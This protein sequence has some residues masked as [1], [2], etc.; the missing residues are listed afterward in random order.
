MA[1]NTSSEVAL[2]NLHDR[3]DA[4]DDQAPRS[5]GT[6][7]DEDHGF[8]F[9]L[10]QVDGGKEAWLLLA[11]SF[12]VEALTWGFPFSFG[13]FQEY[14]AT[15]EPFSREPSGI[16]II[17]SSAMGFMYLGLPFTFAIMQH[18]PRYRLFYAPSGVLI[19]GLALVISSFSTR[20]WQL[21]FT[22]G[23][24]Y[25]LGGTLLYTPTI[26]FLD[27]WF[28]RRKG[29]AYGVMWAGTGVGGICVPLIM[30][31]G[32]DKYGHR[33]MLRAWA[34]ALVT[35]ASPFL[36]FIK[37][38]VPLSTAS[39]PRQLDMKFLRLPLFWA[40]QAGN[41]LE[42]LGFFIPNTWLPTYARS[43][44]F[45]SLEG[46][47]T[48][49]LFNVTSVF[50]Q[51]LMGAL[52]DKLHVTSVIFISTIGATL[53]VFLLWGTAVSLPLLCFFSLTYGLFAG[54]F[55]STYTGVIR[56]VQKQA[57]G[58]EAGMLFGFLSAG[59][60]IGSVLSGPLSEALL[61]GKPWAGEAALGYGTGYGGLIVF[62]GVR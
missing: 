6:A 21:I 18:W 25:A 16:A 59:R 41:V 47:I 49:M 39:R 45:S 37:P 44:G 60:G 5:D 33:I 3:V 48:I 40:L 35:L 20:V 9:S 61:N 11:G 53:S 15:H 14:Y 42:S 24:L 43:L 56:E 34:V 46:T 27:E 12:T 1:S 50:G 7:T 31:W 62:T 57:R 17:G 23:F 30:N 52:V 32:L 19:M 22:Q 51:V 26:S 10:P 38:R 8:E 28:V 36:F 2:A 4:F 54:G 29:F 55:T 58:A 13:I